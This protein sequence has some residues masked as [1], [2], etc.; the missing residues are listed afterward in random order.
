MLSNASC[1]TSWLLRADSGYCGVTRPRSGSSECRGRGGSGSWKLGADEAASWP[2]AAAACLAK[3]DGCAGCRYISISTQWRDCSWHHTCSGPLKT[4]VDGFRSAA[5]CK[6]DGKQGV[7]GSLAEEARAR[8]SNAL[9][10]NQSSSGQPGEREEWWR[11]PSPPP[12]PCVP[13]ACVPRRVA[14][15]LGLPRSGTTWLHEI[16]QQLG[17]QSLH[18]NTR[19]SC[20][21]TNGDSLN[22]ARLLEDMAV[23][24]SAARMDD[25]FTVRLALGR[26]VAAK[27]GAWLAARGA[28]GE[29]S[30]SDALTWGGFEGFGDLPWYAA[31][32]QVLRAIAPAAIFFVTNRS[33]SAWA[34]SVS[35][36]VLRKSELLRSS[37]SRPAWSPLNNYLFNYARELLADAADMDGMALLCSGAAACR[38][39]R[40]ARPTPT[41]GCPTWLDLAGKVYALHAERLRRDFADAVVIDHPDTPAE[42]GGAADGRQ[43]SLQLQHIATIA[44]RLGLPP[45]GRCHDERAVREWT[46][47]LNAKVNADR[48]GRG[49][50]SFAG[51]GL[52]PLASGRRRLCDAV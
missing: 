37:C 43:A 2:A 25:H 7:A 45:L 20:T 24:R 4:N 35:A 36:S 22:G 17:A 8:N 1:T 34:A 52:F 27:P 9:R 44:R 33:L 23:A 41:H 21:H 38:G 48:F 42:D 31:P 47:P 5:T 13:V 50:V 14:F 11:A 40:G 26:Y 3:C 29:P 32:S 6:P 49:V 28:R 16:F 51:G 12:P 39:R 46:L 18:C 19:R 30:H 15:N 10:R